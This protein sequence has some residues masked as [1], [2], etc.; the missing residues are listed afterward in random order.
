[1]KINVLLFCLI[2]F[3]PR[4][5]PAHCQVPCGIYGDGEKFTELEQHV[6]TVAKAF[7]E[8]G[9]ELNPNQQVRWVL[10]K[11][12]HAH[13]IQTELMDYFLTQR[14]KDSQPNYTELL[15]SIHAVAVAAM[16]CKQ[17][18]EVSAVEELRV[19][20]VEFKKLYQESSA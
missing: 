20:L 17:S 15:K 14:I 10:N 11:E 12:S 18:A 6:E 4:L 3:L 2:V 8:L 13:K 5:L 16:K 7:A 1:M 9:S 19:S